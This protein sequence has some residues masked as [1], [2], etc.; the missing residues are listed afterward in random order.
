MNS[1]ILYI[2]LVILALAFVVF[3]GKLWR[4]RTRHRAFVRLLDNADAL[5]KVL[6]QARD[7]MQAMRKVVGRVAPDIG[8]E[9][10]A[11]LDAEPLVQ[12]GLR[13]VLEHR[14]WIAKHAEQA[15]VGELRQAAAALERSHAQIAGQLG[16]LERAGAELD[17]AARA[18]AE[19]EAREPAALRRT[20]D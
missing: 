17:E 3:G 16:Q 5:E 15:S 7:R 14:L 11:S 8:A 19:Q 4:A 20:G 2:P 10:Q 13:N 9:A 6:H 12:Q 18:V 1:L